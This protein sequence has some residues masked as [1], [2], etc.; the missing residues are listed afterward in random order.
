MRLFVAAYPPA[1]ARAHLAAAVAGLAV[2]RAAAQGVNARLADA[3]H[4]HL[5]LA[6][7][8]DV[9]D[10]RGGDAAA[11]LAAGVAAA[12]DPH[13][14]DPPPDGGPPARGPRLWLGG[15][16]RFGRGRF[17][18]LWVG[19]GGETQ[20]VTGLAASVRRELRRARL[21]YDGKPFR[22]HLTLARPGDR[23]DVTGDLA[24]LASYRGP[25]WTLDE[26]CLVRSHLGPRPAYDR[27]ATVALG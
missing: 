5:T 4:W 22:P 9:P 25:E 21:P 11:A 19:V 7:L 6:F 17:T 3:A 20:A 24:A 26:L 1:P 16:G 18:V 14:G 23:V 13:P 27:I 8:G 2:G 10:A 12:R 15:G